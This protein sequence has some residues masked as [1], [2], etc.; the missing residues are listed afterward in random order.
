MMIGLS[1]SQG[2][3]LYM[4]RGGDVEVLDQAGL[5]LGVWSIEHRAPCASGGERPEPGSQY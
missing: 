4:L 1:V 2:L 3:G 5:D